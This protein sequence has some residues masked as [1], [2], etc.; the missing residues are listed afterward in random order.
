MSTDAGARRQAVDALKSQIALTSLPITRRALVNTLKKRGDMSVEALA[1]QLD[2]TVSGVR[3]QLLGLER[4]GFV[5]HAEIRSGPGRPRHVYRLTPAAHGLYPKAYADLTNELLE[6]VD[7]SD[8]EL[9][10]HIFR[11][12]RERRIAGARERMEGRDVEG[13]I[14]ELTRILDEDGYLADCEQLDDGAWVLTERNCA[15]FGVAMKYGQACGSELDFIRTVLPDAKIER[16]AHM[17]AGAHNCSYRIEF[18]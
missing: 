15:I 4:D 10:E 1:E 5:T 3:Q 18:A 7:D 12:R 13:K 9:V 2:L 14:A 8:P 11:R 16:I 17:V 6:Y